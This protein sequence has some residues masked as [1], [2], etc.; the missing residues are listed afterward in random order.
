M[1]DER[2]EFYVSMLKICV[3]AMLAYFSFIYV[4]PFFAVLFHNNVS[5]SP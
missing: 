2:Y 5:V 4:Y 3:V 1:K